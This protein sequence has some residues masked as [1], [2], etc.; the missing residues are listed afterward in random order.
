M[1]EK[2]VREDSKVCMEKK[3]MKELEDFKDLLD[4]EDYRFVLT[5]KKNRKEER[6]HWFYN[7]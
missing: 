1:M 5:I 2:Q 4:L 3:E 6:L 7:A